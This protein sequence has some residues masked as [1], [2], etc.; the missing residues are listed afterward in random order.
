MAAIT[1]NL[2]YRTPFCD[3]KDQTPYLIHDCLCK[4]LYALSMV[5]R[6]V[7]TLFFDRDH[8]YT[9]LS[10]AY[11]AFFQGANP[12]FN[13]YEFGK[14][15]VNFSYNGC[16][17]ARSSDTELNAL[18]ARYGSQVV[19]QW[20]TIGTK[21][22]RLN[23]K[24]L[25]RVEDGTCIGMSLDFAQRFLQSLQNRTL[26]SDAIRLISSRYI[27]G[28]PDQAQLAQIFS[29]A[30]DM[31]EVESIKRD[32]IAQMTKETTEELEREAHRIAGEVA[33][34][35]PFEEAV[36]KNRFDPVKKKI[37]AQNKRKMIQENI[38]I[39]SKRLKI[40]GEQLGLQVGNPEIC[41]L[42]EIRFKP[43]P[44]FKNTVESLAEGCHL[45][46]FRD[47]QVGHLAVLIK[48]SD[49]HYY[50]FDPNIGTLDFKD[51][52]IVE[53]LWKITTTSY[54]KNLGSS[55]SFS[56]CTLDDLFFNTTAY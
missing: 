46:S 47:N 50:L 34:T 22:I 44:D 48:S 11:A 19:G 24:K 45:I 17:I 7:A 42:D 21:E 4:S 2:E 41:I 23:T 26:A 6:S 35:P 53:S 43:D 39:D 8:S 20:L 55:I 15:V 52:E 13:Y 49:G 40:I 9:Y 25:K 37:L 28:A 27:T 33:K 14:R 16:V 18:N 54:L 3:I 12:I 36:F 32:R 31:T 56:L 5:I 10:T 38:A 51:T 30:L 29:K 1:H